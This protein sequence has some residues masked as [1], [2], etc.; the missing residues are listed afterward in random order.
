MEQYTIL[1]NIGEGAH[2]I[3]FKAKYKQNGQTVALKKVRLKKLE[4]GIPSTAIRE[5]KALQ[6]IEDNPYDLKPANLLISSTGHLKIADFGLARVF[7]NS[8]NCEYSHQVATRW[9]RAPE[10]L[11]GAR[12]YDEGVDLWAVGCIFGELL[13]NSPLFP[14][15]NDIEQ[16]CC[17]LRVLGTPTEKTWPGM[18]EL[19][20]F[21]KITFPENPA[22]PIKEI[23][24]DA[25]AHASDLL[26]KFLVYPSKERI[27]AKKALLHPY[28]FSVPL[29]C[30]HSDLP[31]PY[32]GWQMRRRQQTHDYNPDIPLEKSLLPLEAL[33]FFMNQ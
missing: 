29:P 1:G 22:I 33:T 19:P 23:V 13:N 32:R 27:A 2:G 7:Q 31:V 10:L 16:L 26:G 25:S 9:Y 14:G 21:K 30:H 12:K 8:N 11:Y 17:V 24:P 4:D 6:Q 28:F 5:I 3:V 20:D 18:S 15:D